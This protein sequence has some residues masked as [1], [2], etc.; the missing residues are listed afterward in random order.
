MISSPQ[1]LQQELKSLPIMSRGTSATPLFLDHNGKKEFLAEIPVYQGSTGAPVIAYQG[2]NNTR[3]DEP[4]SGHRVLLVGILSGTYTKGFQQRIVL[5]GSY[6][7][8]QMV[9][10]ENMG[11]V[12]K[13]QRLLEFKNLLRVEKK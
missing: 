10:H 8:E 2:N 11:V 6:P 12:I 3:N 7:N 5:K 1:G 9:A 13:A 4:M